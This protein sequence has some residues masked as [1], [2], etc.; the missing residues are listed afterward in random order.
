MRNALNR[1]SGLTD[2]ALPFMQRTKVGDPIDVAHGDV[3]QAQTDITLPGAMPLVLS[4]VHISSYDFGRWFGTSWASTLDQRLEID[5]SGACFATDDGMLLAF[6]PLTG[7]DAVAPL[8]GPAYTLRR[9]GDEYTLI[10]PGLGR[11]LVFSPDGSDAG[12]AAVAPGG[13]AVAPLV[14]VSDRNGHRID[15]LRATSGEDLVGL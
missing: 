3:V 8:V 1:L 12:G 10:E 14:S 13:A 2:R 5:S 9:S 4:R 6:P 15:V 11:T 7:E